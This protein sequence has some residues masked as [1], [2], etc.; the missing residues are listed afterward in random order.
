MSKEYDKYLKQHRENVAK[1]YNWLKENLPE[2]IYTGAFDPD[3]WGKEVTMF[4]DL[5]KDDSYEYF[6]YDAYFYGGNRS[7][8]VTQDFNKAWLFHIHRN[9][10]HW[11]HWVLINDD[12][13]EGIVMLDM[14]Y[15]YIIEMICDW[16]AFSWAKGNLKEI[17]SW[18]DERK[19]YIQLSPATRKQLEYLLT[20]IKAKL[21]ALEHSEGRL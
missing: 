21:D 7:Y 16:W 8:Q 18:Y 1:G 3:E 17:F 14:P 6:A 11:Q 13:N 19:N 20:K 4:H 10:H 2:V 12:Q 5:T 15:N 9:P